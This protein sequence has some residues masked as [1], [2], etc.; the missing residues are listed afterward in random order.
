MLVR[1]HIDLTFRQPLRGA[2]GWKNESLIKRCPVLYDRQYM[3]LTRRAAEKHGVRLKEGVLC[4]S[5]GPSYETGAE[6]EFMRRIG[7]DSACM[8]TAHEVLVANTLDLRVLGL[9]CISNLATGVG[10]A[11]LSHDEVAEVV[12]RTVKRI[13]PFLKEVVREIGT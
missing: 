9:S 12:G 7:A 8:S 10:D 2:C 5:K 13:V 1:D 11:E 4:S 6:S 3:E